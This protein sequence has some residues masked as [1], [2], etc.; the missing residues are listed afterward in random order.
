[1]EKRLASGIGVW[2]EQQI[3]DALQAVNEANEDIADLVPTAEMR[4]Y[5]RGYVAAINAISAT[6]GCNYKATP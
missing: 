5:R 2:F 6:F 3:E 4:I 1:M